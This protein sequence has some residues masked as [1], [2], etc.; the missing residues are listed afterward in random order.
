MAAARRAPAATDAYTSVEDDVEG[1]THRDAVAGRRVAPPPRRWV[2]RYQHR[3]DSAGGARQ[4]Q[5]WWPR[6][7][8]AQH[9]LGRRSG[10]RRRVVAGDRRRSWPRCRRHPRPR[11][12]GLQACVARTRGTRLGGSARRRR[13]LHGRRRNRPHLR[14]AHRRGGGRRG[15]HPR[16]GRRNRRRASH[17][18]ASLGPH[19]AALG[20][21]ARGH[22]RHAAPGRVAAQRRLEGRA[23]VAPKYSAPRTRAQATPGA[24]GAASS[25]L[26]R[27]CFLCRRPTTTH[28]LGRRRKWWA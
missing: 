18:H 21:A 11:P 12:R 19:P 27:L 2:G 14:L 28:G 10:G 24:G 6:L 16:A 15:P 7:G 8:W 22:V 17:R 26:Q 5:R 23:A 13:H 3:R 20:R 1:W 4:G 9:G 25:C